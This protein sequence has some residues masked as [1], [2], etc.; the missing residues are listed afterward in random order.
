[1]SATG[2]FKELMGL[3]AIWQTIT[4]SG[5]ANE[6]AERVITHATQDLDPD[7]SDTWPALPFAVV[8]QGSVRRQKIGDPA[9]FSDEGT[10]ILRIVF[11]EPGQA[12]EALDAIVIDGYCESL[13]GQLEARNGGAGVFDASEYNWDQPEHCPATDHARGTWEVTCEI[14]YGEDG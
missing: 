6:A 13:R 1:M 7:D 14:R 5:S 4:G 10:L 12:T 11:D 9:T 2:N 3:C 8:V